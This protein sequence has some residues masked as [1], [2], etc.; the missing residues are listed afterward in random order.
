MP[1]EAGLAGFE[2]ALFGF[3]EDWAGSAMAMPKLPQILGVDIA[4][5]PIFI[6]AGKP[7]RVLLKIDLDR[8]LAVSQQSIF[9][10][11]MVIWSSWQSHLVTGCSAGLSGS[12][13]FQRTTSSGRFVDSYNWMSLSMVALM[14]R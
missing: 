13:A 1:P 10:N 2:Q 6:R 7:E 12:I 8:M 4:P 5:R 3:V 9:Q 11:D 14:C